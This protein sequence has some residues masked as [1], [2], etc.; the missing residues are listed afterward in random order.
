MHPE[1]RWG[2]VGYVP[3]ARVDSARLTELLAERLRMVIISWNEMDASVCG[4]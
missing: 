4:A 1:M 2:G 3:S